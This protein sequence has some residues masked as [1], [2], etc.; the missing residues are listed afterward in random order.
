MTNAGGVLRNSFIYNVRAINIARFIVFRYEMFTTGARYP[1][2]DIL[3]ADDM[4]AVVDD[5]MTY[6][7]EDPKAFTLYSGYAPNIF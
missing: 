4:A 1:E 2:R 3:R 5:T 6:N 7:P